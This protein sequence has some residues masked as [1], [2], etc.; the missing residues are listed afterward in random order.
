MPIALAIGVEP[1]LLMAAVCKL[2]PEQSELGLAGALQGSAI[3]LM[4][5]ETSDLL[6]PAQAEK[7]KGKKAGKAKA[8][9]DKP[10]E[11]GEK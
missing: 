6:V 4:K 8:E 7:A 5:C 3:D 2:P 1:A 11:G 9:G 10:K